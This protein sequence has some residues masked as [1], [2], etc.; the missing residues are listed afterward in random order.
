M[1]IVKGIYEHFKGKRYEVI[2]I[3]RHSETLE[4]MVV[5]KALYKGDFPEG[6]L[7][8]RPLGMF[9]ESVSLEGKQVPRFRLIANFLIAFL[10]LART[11]FAVENT[12][13]LNDVM[14]QMTKFLN[15]TEE[16]VIAVRPIV[17]TSM[18]KRQRFI[19]SMEADAIPDKK[20]F[21]SIMLK[22]RDEEDLELSKVLTEEQMNKMKQRRRTR[23]SLNKDQIDFSEGIAS[24]A[25]LGLQGANMQF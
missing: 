14:A 8:V 24:T 21:R 23:E 13:S 10:I 7:W 11:A 3:A 9:K 6:S 12:T 16:Q 18:L 5:Y 19:N 2:D 17:K 22:Q 4:P 25:S 1:D 15:L 20:M